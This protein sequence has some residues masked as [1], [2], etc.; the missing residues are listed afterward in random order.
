MTPGILNAQTLMP[1]VQMFQVLSR[2]ALALVGRARR[3]ACSA[4]DSTAC[5]MLPCWVLLGFRFLISSDTVCCTWILV[6]LKVLARIANR[7]RIR[8]QH[9]GGRV[10]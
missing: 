7:A 6:D 1:L 3:V 10:G 9:T 5:P 8:Q 4:P 2:W